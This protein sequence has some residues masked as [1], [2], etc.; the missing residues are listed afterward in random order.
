VGFP[1]ALGATKDDKSLEKD[2]A[3]QTKSQAGRLDW[4][5]PPWKTDCRRHPSAPFSAM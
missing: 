5:R 3:E 1:L 4:P 2:G